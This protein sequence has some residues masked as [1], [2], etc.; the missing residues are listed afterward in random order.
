MRSE[1]RASTRSLAHVAALLLV[2]RLFTAEAGE[3]FA[4]ESHFL[5]PCRIR[6]AG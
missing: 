1:S 3:V 5:L 4:K 2:V 6:D